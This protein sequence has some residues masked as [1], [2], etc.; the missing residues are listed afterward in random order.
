MNQEKIGRFIA[1]ARKEKGY[2]QEQLAEK[3][4][5]SNRTVS[6]W[7]N[8]KNMPD[9]SLF[10][11]LCEALDITVNELLAGETIEKEKIETVSEQN[12]MA[13]SRHLERKSKI[14]MLLEAGVFILVFLLIVAMNI[15]EDNKT[16]MTNIY[17]SDYCD[18]VQ[19]SVP[20][21]SYYR[22]TAGLDTYYVKLKTLKQT[23][24]IDVFIDRYLST[25]EPIECND[26]TYYY[27]AKSD[28]TIFQYTANNDGVGFV[29]TI[30][31]GYHDGKYCGDS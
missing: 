21:F 9:V 1:K 23:D 25:F 24:E 19:I 27:N 20:K 17:R 22:S 28:F 13:L 7:E 8:G 6:R 2:T 4:G 15:L 30:Y 3:L 18:N 11:S 14:K 12:M 29:N 26:K 5:V 16:F 31:I 10:E